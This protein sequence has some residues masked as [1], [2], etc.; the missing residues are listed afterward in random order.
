MIDWAIAASASYV[1]AGVLQKVGEGYFGGQSDRK[2][3]QLVG[4]VADKIKTQTPTENHELAKAF[5]RA[6]LTAMQ[7]ICDSRKTTQTGRSNLAVQHNIAGGF[8]GDTPKSVFAEDEGQWL[9]KANQYLKTQIERLNQ[10]SDF[11]PDRETATYRYV[12]NPK[13]E[14]DRIWAKNVEKKLTED[15][16]AELKENVGEPSKSIGFEIENRWFTQTS[17]EF[18]KALAHNETLANKFQN[19]MLTVLGAGQREI[20]QFLQMMFTNVKITQNDLPELVGSLIEKTLFVNRETEKANLEEWLTERSRKIIVIEGISGYGKTSLLMEILH[21]ISPNGKTLGGKLDAVLVFLCREGEGSFREVCRKVD[22]RLGK[23][24]DA[25]LRRY[26]NFIENRRDKPEEIP[27]EIIGG[28]IGELK[29]LGN[30]WMVFDNF[31]TVLENQIITEP[32]LR[33]FFEKALQ[34]DGIGFLLTSQKVPEFEVFAK[35]EEILV[36][37]LPAKDALEFFRAEGKRLKENNKMPIDCGLAEITM[38]DLAKLEQLKFPFV[39][40]ALVA[41][42]GY[43]E[44]SYRKEGTTLAKVLEDETLFA[45]FREHDAKEGSM[46]LIGLQYE[47]SSAAERLI[48]KA[49]SIFPQAIEYPA[50]ETILKDQIDDETLFSILIG[51]SLIKGIQPNL[52]ELLPQAKEAVSKQP[53]RE[54]EALTRQQLH[55][56]AAEFYNSIRQPIAECYTQKDFEPY[57]NAIDHFIKAENNFAVIEIFNEAME[58]FFGFGYMQKVIEKCRIIS[59]KLN[60]PDLEANNFMNIGLS[61]DFLGKFDKAIIEHDKGIDIFEQLV[62]SGQ[63]KFVDDLAS[64]YLNKGNT[65]DSLGKLNESVEE[66]DKA[67]KIL[68]Q[69]TTTGQRILAKIY[70]NKGVALYNQKNLSEAIIEYDKTIK[71]YNSLTKVGVIELPF[72]LAL[73]HMNKGNVLYLFKKLDEAINEYNKAIEIREKLIKDQRINITNDL[74]KVYMNKGLV[75]FDLNKSD[76]A[77]IEHNKTIEIYENLVNNGRIELSRD[78]ALAYMN[79]G[80]A[81]FVSSEM[82]SA[83][84]EYEKTIKIYEKLV[85][86]GNTELLNYLAIAFTNKGNILHAL[87][88]LNEEIAEYNKAIDEHNKAINIQEKLVKQGNT[89]S[90]DDLARTYANKGFVLI[91]LNKRNEAVDIYSKAINLWEDSLKHGE[92]QNL[93]NLIKIL[94]IRIALLGEFKDLKSIA[95]DIAKAF[96]LSLPVLQNSD[97]SDHFKQLINTEISWILRIMCEGSSEIREEIYKNADE[98]G[99]QIKEIV[100]DFCTEQ[101]NSDK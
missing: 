91:S 30:V 38:E 83:N 54:D 94:K 16:F 3:C 21:K 51:N 70:M 98:M 75:F 81:L 13:D 86:D 20:M 100:E 5:R 26:E 4:K 34:F 88:K 41:L 35:I 49:L 97:F 92:V 9:E 23:D 25:F 2:I 69:S 39:P 45:K 53:D 32:H 10:N 22:E 1:A 99:E 18:Q 76:E 7:N 66:Y 47:K 80:N 87:G 19:L 65:L 46:Y 36:E 48:L 59:G 29:V 93:P 78:L 57:F 89:E 44:K 37:T 50:L 40:Q 95:L 61:L 27:H 68:K 28:I 43:F 73:A 17:N 77:I 14:N 82:N 71:I 101:Q 52:Y 60:R 72:D 33:A 79:K 12:V 90:L 6:G 67:I 55:L 62:E 31:E 58:R 56:K 42:V 74:A 11:L 64:A 8:L 24:Q 96:S 85:E 63:S 15:I 84:V